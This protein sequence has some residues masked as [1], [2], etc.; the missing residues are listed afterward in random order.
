M[1][2][3]EEIDR[4]IQTI[5]EEGNYIPKGRIKDMTF[6]MYFDYASKAFNAAGYDTEGMPP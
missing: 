6:D 3:N 5:E 4:F 1:D 2:T